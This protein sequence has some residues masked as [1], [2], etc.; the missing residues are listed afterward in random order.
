MFSYLVFLNNYFT[1]A[2]TCLKL[3][4]LSEGLEKVNRQWHTGNLWITVQSCL[5]FEGFLW[6][7]KMCPYLSF[8]PL[9]AVLI[10]P[11]ILCYL[12]LILSPW[13]IW[14]YSD[15][16]HDIYCLK[17][18]SALSDNHC[19]NWVLQLGRQN[20]EL[21][22]ICAIPDNLS[23]NFLQSSILPKTYD[24]SDKIVNSTNGKEAVFQIPLCWPSPASL[25]STLCSVSLSAVQ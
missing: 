2:T 13:S 23:V 25:A 9:C 20:Q 15:F 5:D 14:R 3:Y 24:F 17:T 4:Q 12:E 1:E 22:L 8:Y 18:A 21:C 11:S 6:R 16:A 19:S 7:R 10:S